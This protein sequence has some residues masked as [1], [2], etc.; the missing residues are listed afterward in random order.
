MPTPIWGWSKRHGSGYC[1]AG[2]FRRVLLRPPGGAGDT[3]PTAS[4]PSATPPL[5]PNREG[6]KPGEGQ[7]T[8][9]PDGRRSI[10]ATAA[11]GGYLTA[12]SELTDVEYHTTRTTTLTR[13]FATS[14]ST[15]AGATPER[16]TS[17]FG[18]SI[19]IGPSSRPVRRP[20]GQDRQ[21]HRPR[22]HYR[23]VDPLGRDFVLRFLTRCVWRVPLARTRA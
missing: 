21:H 5:L 11:N 23:R 9:G 16:T 20:A 6:S 7:I 13:A 8:G 3:P 1:S 4:S 17:W 14:A 2:I 15:M 12:A 22:H 10:A 18:P 19:R